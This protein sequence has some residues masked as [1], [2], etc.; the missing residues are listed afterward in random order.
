[1]FWKRK[2]EEE[3][4]TLI[5]ETQ[6]GEFAWEH[7]FAWYCVYKHKNHELNSSYIFSHVAYSSLRYRR[8]S[9]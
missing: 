7:S 1:M 5:V 2:K 6:F 3:K 9:R 4:E 8:S